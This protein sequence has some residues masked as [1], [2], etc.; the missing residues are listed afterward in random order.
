[1]L[2][3]SGS[4]PC[5]GSHA[6]PLCSSMPEPLVSI[7]CP[8]KNASEYLH[9]LIASIKAQSYINWELLLVDDC[10]TDNSFHIV[11]SAAI[12]DSRIR[13]LK[14]PPRECNAM[15]GPWWPRNFAL[16]NSS[17]FLVAFIDA[18]DLWHPQKLKSQIHI[19]VNLDFLMSVTWCLR[20][21]PVMKNIVGKRRPP[22]SFAYTQLRKANL[23]PML[24]VVVA[25]NLLHDRF[26]PS[27]HED[28]L[29]WLNLFRDQPGLRCYTLPEYLSFYRVH[30]GSLSS[31][32]LKMP[33]WV[34][35]VFAKH[36]GN[37]FLAL[38]MLFP[39]SVYQ[40]QMLVGDLLPR[41]RMKLMG[42]ALIKKLFGL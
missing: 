1:M 19:H 37:K 35:G 2:F 22:T 42:S 10:S 4:A 30:K 8:Y 17:G 40:L 24:S 3:F 18:D 7:I 39:W 25:R 6:T 23:V 20:F 29:F 16:D 38:A 36:T 28:Y 32:R 11:Q 5:A 31:S 12:E 27:R 9:G 14:A 21:D 26:L 41:Y 13:S 15:S 34:F 33:F